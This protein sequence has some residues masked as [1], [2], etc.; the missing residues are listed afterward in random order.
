MRDLVDLMRRWVKTV[1]GWNWA[2]ALVKP[3]TMKALIWVFV[4]TMRVVGA[5]LT[6]IRIFRE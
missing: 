5:L 4:W 2:K 1:R 6:L 3:A